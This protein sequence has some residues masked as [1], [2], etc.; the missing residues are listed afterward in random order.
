MGRFQYSDAE[1]DLNK[2]LK[3]NL[4]ESESLLRDPELLESRAEA[5]ESIASSMELLRS[6]GKSA[7]VD[8]LS[9]QL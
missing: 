4:D 7:Q 9:S 3:M 1:M 8:K 5:D 2:V 6:L